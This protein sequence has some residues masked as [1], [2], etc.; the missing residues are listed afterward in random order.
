MGLPGSGINVRSLDISSE[1]GFLFKSLYEDSLRQS[2]LP[3]IYETTPSMKDF[4]RME[5]SLN[6]TLPETLEGFLNDV[7]PD[8]IIAAHPFILKMLSSIKHT[9]VGRIPVM[10]LVSEFE[11]DS[12]WAGSP[13]GAYVIPHEGLKDVLAG[14][15]VD[16]RCIF[17]LGI[18]AAASC[19]EAFTS[20]PS[21]EKQPLSVLIV[22]SGLSSL[23][24]IDLASDIARQASDIQISILP[25]NNAKAA[26]LVRNLAG[27]EEERV[28]ILPVSTDASE[29]MKKAS[30]LVTRPSGFILAMA[31]LYRLPAA[32]MVPPHG[33]GQSAAHY[34]DD[35]GAVRCLSMDGEWADGILTLL[36]DPGMLGKL[37][38]GISAL[39]KPW[40]APEISLLAR[41]MA[42]REYSK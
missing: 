6:S 19:S 15:G 30:L 41:S 25:G 26:R 9:D 5:E 21:K 22:D 11:I 7:L 16:R 35:H 3:W 1:A 24:L 27:R 29:I 14:F 23:P 8:I 18:P 36:H 13:A 4:N 33:L 40:A 12:D 17:S 31:A 10:A 28:S 37:G 39:A 20:D 34:L 2:T 42:L 38:E 32:L